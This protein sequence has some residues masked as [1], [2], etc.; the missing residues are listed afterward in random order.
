[1][2][3]ACNGAAP[4]Y[5]PDMLVF[6]VGLLLLP[7]WGADRDR[8]LRAMQEVMGPFG[9]PSGGAPVVKVLNERETEHYVQRKIEFASPDGEMVP[10]WLFVPRGR[11]GPFPAMMCL[12]QTTRIGK[13]EPAGMGP[14]VNLHYAVGLA[15][16]GFVALAPDYPGFGEYKI[17][18]YA[19]GYQS[20]TMKGIRNHMRAVDVLVA[21]KEVDP[22]RIGAI[23]HSLGG[24][25]ALFLAVFDR[26][27][28]AVV[29][30]C[31][32]T[33]FAKYY[34]GDLTGWSHKG[35]MPRIATVYGKSPARMPFDFGDVLAAIAPRPIFVNAP[36]GDANF[37][38]TGADDCVR[39]SGHAAIEVAHPDCEHDFPPEVRARAYEFLEE[40][41]GR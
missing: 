30:S 34:G 24:H 21:M 4:L 39:Q 41:L 10:A 9:P 36:L 15:E 14:R 37:D 40:R 3:V 7:A 5:H 32:F 33:S 27:I 25:N 20:A 11:T 13:D 16:R 26:R 29:T 23:G 22:R 12:H 28:A 17:D 31:G 8:T 6:L 35:Y 2:R 18:S 1:M 38:Y 19:M